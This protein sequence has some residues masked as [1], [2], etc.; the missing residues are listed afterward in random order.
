MSIRALARGGLAQKKDLVSPANKVEPAQ[1]VGGLCRKMVSAKRTPQPPSAPRSTALVSDDA[2]LVARACA[3]DRWAEDAIYR[4]HAPALTRLCTRVLGRAEDADDVV[5]DT[6]VTA[7]AKL[8]TVREPAALRGWL[9]RVAV[10][11]ARRRL[12]KRKWLSYVGLAPDAAEVGLAVQAHE[13]ARPELRL[14]LYA[15]DAVL[16]RES[17]DERMTW[18]LHRVEELS[19]QETAEATGRSL[20][21]VK[22]YVAAVDAR[23]ARAC[24]G[25][26]D[27]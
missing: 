5:Q 27:G 25:R 2:A 22:R 13:H 7:F 4:R 26:E 8:A 11:L 10:H 9:V 21:T 18:L 15:L 12:R 19:L 14:E 24:G 6:F 17:S 16:A 3:G 1:Q 23:V 20:A